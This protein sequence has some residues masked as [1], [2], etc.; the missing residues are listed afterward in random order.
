MEGSSGWRKKK[1]VA[2]SPVSKEKEKKGK[3]RNENKK[4]FPL[5]RNLKKFIE[6]LKKCLENLEKF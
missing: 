6:K 2:G 1:R 3:K 5:P 4:V